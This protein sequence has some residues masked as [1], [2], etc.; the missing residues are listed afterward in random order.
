MRVYDD[1]N[2]G[3]RSEHDDE[4]D[5]DGNVD[6]WTPTMTLYNL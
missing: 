2:D 6:D 3:D 1:D 4:V 5:D